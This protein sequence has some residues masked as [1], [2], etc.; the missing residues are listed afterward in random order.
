M[1]RKKPLFLSQDSPSSQQTWRFCIKP[2]PFPERALSA[3]FFCRKDYLTE[4]ATA[5]VKLFCRQ[6]KM[7]IVGSEHS[8]TP[9]ITTP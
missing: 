2:S 8:V 5:L 6:K 1:R 3:Y 7:I 4:P 9:A